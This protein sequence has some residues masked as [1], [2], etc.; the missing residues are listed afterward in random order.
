MLCL[1]VCAYNSYKASTGEG[2][3]KQTHTQK[4]RQVKPNQI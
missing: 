2:E 1:F 4:Y 3:I